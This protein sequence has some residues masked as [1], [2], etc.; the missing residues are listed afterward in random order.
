M[1]A[2]TIRLGLAAKL[3]V[4]VIASTAAFF[5]LFGCINLRLERR[6]A[7]DLVIQSADRVSDVILRSTRYEMLRFYRRVVEVNLLD[8]R[9][10]VIALACSGS[11]RS[12][13]G[14][15][16]NYARGRRT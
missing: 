16:W 3:A 2:S 8:P 14:S 5:A 12:A 9:W 6:Q 1:T 7:M 13:G 10:N 11:A 4:C 15:E